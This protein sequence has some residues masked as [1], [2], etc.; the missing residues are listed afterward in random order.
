[1]E[2]V[3]LKCFKQTFFGLGSHKS[4]TMVDSW[5]MQNEGD[6]LFF[7]INA[8]VKKGGWNLNLHQMQNAFRP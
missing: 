1:M 7:K 8:V 6:E 4:S 3:S 5:R 2:D